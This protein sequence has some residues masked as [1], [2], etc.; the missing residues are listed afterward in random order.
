[1]VIS[2]Q[3]K[4]R[5]CT[6]GYADDGQRNI[7]RIQRNQERVVFVSMG[8]NENTEKPRKSRICINGTEREYREAPRKSC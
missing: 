8:Q 4:S 1:M 5:I 2:I 3:G 7:M 6:M